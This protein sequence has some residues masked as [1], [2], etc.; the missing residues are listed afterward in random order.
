MNR[1]RIWLGL[2]VVVVARRRCRLGEHLL[3]DSGALVS[4]P[5]DT[6]V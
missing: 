5:A 1:Q 4:N 2:A 3:S 6:P